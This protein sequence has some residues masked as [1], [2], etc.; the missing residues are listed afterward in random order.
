MNPKSKHLMLA[1]RTNMMRTPRVIM[2]QSPK[3]RNEAEFPIKRHSIKDCTQ[4]EQLN[5]LSKDTPTEEPPREGYVNLDV[6]ENVNY[7][8]GVRSEPIEDRKFKLLP[9]E[10][11]QTLMDIVDQ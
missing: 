1:Q 7:R 4:D 3:I 8:W 6:M 11:P 5:S 10:S 9:N 2:N